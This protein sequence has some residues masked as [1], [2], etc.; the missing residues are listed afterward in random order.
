MKTET[1]LKFVENRATLQEQEQV[2][3]WIKESPQNRKVYAKLKN[4]DVAMELA[5]YEAGKRK[6]LLFKYLRGAAKIAAVLVIAFSIFYIGE[7]V[8]LGKWVK[9]AENQIFEVKAPY[10][11]TLTFTFPDSTEVILN[12]G[13]T[14][15]YSNLY[16]YKNRNVSIT[17]EGYFKVRKNDE[18]F[19]VIYPI[20]NPLF[21]ATVLGTEFNISSYKEDNDIVTDLYK[22]S[23]Q[24]ENI[25]QNETVVM[26]PNT[27]YIFSKETS[28]VSIKP[29][30]K[31]LKWMDSYVIA[32]SEDIVSFSKKLEKVFKVDI[33]VS[34]EL[35]GTCSYS[36]VLYGKSLRQILDDMSLV[37]P[38]KY[39]FTDKGK[40]VIIKHR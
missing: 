14:L 10:G 13:T 23:I 19:N 6:R 40:S 33:V 30:T 39:T 12:S 29:I 18:E 26:T 27:S 28:E 16:G 8:G 32:D 25:S 24:I 17:G 2:L 15:Q 35:V 21:K 37:S 7:R 9:Y 11:E 22:G 31:P 4:I 34:S 20:E 1:I 5:A 3:A 36:G 38:I